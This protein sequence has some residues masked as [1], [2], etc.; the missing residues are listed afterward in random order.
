MTTGQKLARKLRKLA[1]LIDPR[2]LPS[3][4]Q[5]IRLNVDAADA[6]KVLEAFAERVRALKKDLPR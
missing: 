5:T 1:D 4:E 2:V 6:E 3:Q